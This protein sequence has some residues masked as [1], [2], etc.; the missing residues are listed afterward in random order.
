MV[1]HVH[2][3][4]LCVAMTEQF[5]SHIQSKLDD[6]EI[7]GKYKQIGVLYLTYS[8]ANFLRLYLR[9]KKY[10]HKYVVL[11]VAPLYR[12]SGRA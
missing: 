9:R 2:V 4:L 11:C 8:V 10:V 12:T 7:W 3:I 1:H 5:C 6:P